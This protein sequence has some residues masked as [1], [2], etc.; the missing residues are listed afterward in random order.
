MMGLCSYSPWVLGNT[1]KDHSLKNLGMGASYNSSLYTYLHFIF[2]LNNLLFGYIYTY[3]LSI[4]Y[5]YHPSI[6]FGLNKILPNEPTRRVGQAEVE[7]LKPEKQRRLRQQSHRIQVS[8]GKKG[9][10]LFRFLFRG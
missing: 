8:N 5:I 2:L 1:K 7:E 3:T 10:W 4:F 6:T 9:P